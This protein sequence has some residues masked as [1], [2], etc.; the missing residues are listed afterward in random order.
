MKKYILAG[1]L[2]FA[3]SLEG[4]QVLG[5]NI[6]ALMTSQFEP[7]I[8]K[9]ADDKKIPGFAIAVVQ[10]GDIVYS[11]AFGVKN[12][13]TRE[14]MKTQSLFHQASVTKTFVATAIMQFVE[15]GKI[16]LDDP[17]I[18]YL[19]YFKLA[20]ERYKTITIRQMLAHTSG[21]P[22]VSDYE[23]DK[24]VYDDGALEKYVGK[25]QN[26]T[27][28]FK[29]GTDAKYSNMAYD[30]LGDLIAKVSG[31][32]FADYVQTNILTPLKMKNSTLLKK[33]AD[34]N[35]LTTPH[36]DKDDTLIV[37]KIYPYNRM[38]GPSSCL[39]SNVEDMCR[40]AMANLNHGELD[41]TRI[42]NESAYEI[43]WNQGS[44][45]SKNIGL[46]WFIRE[47]K[48]FKTVYFLGG[49]TGYGSF[50]CLIPEKS[51]GIVWSVNCDRNWLLEV[52][53]MSLD[54]ALEIK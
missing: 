50:L 34:L 9:A 40:W 49:D 5:Q 22:D 10:N 25:I 28:L 53:D 12:I 31:I 54:I 52:V 24:P 38:H 45:I 47:Y 11:K 27:L 21:M 48:G 30:V 3:I 26:E 14:K 16:K 42:L 43:L 17:V 37:S 33:Q 29:P 51:L 8:T 36:I 15:Q 2:L 41:G 23:W 19:P 4:G 20:D 32:T 46:G 35:L 6:N 39:I 44:E 18:K 7:Y 1:L 13:Q